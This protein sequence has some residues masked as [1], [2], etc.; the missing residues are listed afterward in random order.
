[1]D[2]LIGVDEDVAED[3]EDGVE[4]RREGEGWGEE[5]G[6]RS[7]VGE[8]GGVGEVEGGGVGRGVREGGE[9]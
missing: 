9:S 7:F 8:E 5:V 2:A 4:V 3:G 6:V 1:M